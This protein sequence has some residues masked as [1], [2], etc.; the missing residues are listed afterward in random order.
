MWLV[1]FAMLEIKPRASHKHN[2]HSANFLYPMPVSSNYNTLFHCISY[3]WD[4]AIF[5]LN[6]SVLC[7]TM[8]FSECLQ[9]ETPFYKQPSSPFGR[10]KMMALG[11][12][13]EWCH[14][15]NTT[16]VPRHAEMTYSWERTRYLIRT[17]AWVETAGEHGD[18]K[19]ISGKTD[20]RSYWTHQAKE[21]V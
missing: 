6:Y 9:T 18:I 14:L 2:K 11:W 21:R 17:L 13:S 16:H 7:K 8:V 4:Q 1:G 20:P 10:W 5:T 3:R 15:L 12:V 19:I